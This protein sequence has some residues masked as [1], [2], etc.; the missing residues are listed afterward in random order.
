MK[1]E[2][3]KFQMIKLNKYAREYI[4]SKDI[5]INY[6]RISKQIKEFSGAEYVIFNIFEENGKDFKI[7]SLE[8]DKS[9]LNKVINVIGFKLIGKRFKYDK[10]RNEK[11]EK[12][13]VTKVKNL[14]E[15]IGDTLPPKSLK[16]L[17]KIFPIS[18]ILILR[19][20]KDDKNIGN[21]TLF[22]YEDIGNH[23]YDMLKLFASQVGLF[24]DKKKEEQKII[25]MNER[26]ENI[27]KGTNVGTWELDV[28]TGE[29]LI[30][31]RWAEMI[32]YKLEE[33]LP[34]TKE[35]REELIHPDDLGKL[36][37]Q[38]QRSLNKEIGSYDVEFRKRHKNGKWVW[39]N[40]RAKVTKWSEDGK[41]LVVSGALT[42]ITEKI[43]YENKIINQRDYMYKI[44]NS[45]TQYVIVIGLDYR[46]QFMNESAIENLGNIKGKICYKEL[47]RSK[48]CEG[49]RINELY[50]IEE[51]KSLKFVVNAFNKDLEISASKIE[52]KDGST[53]IVEVIDDITEKIKRQKKIEYLNFHDHLT[54]LHNRR[55]FEV[56]LERI[57]LEINLPL[58]IIMLD[59]NGLKLINDTF[60][61]NKGD[62]ILI[63]SSAAIKSV[64]KEGD[65]AIRSGGDEFLII[66]PKCNENQSFLIAERIKEKIK[67][68][69]ER[70]I[71]FS[72]ASGVHTKK[73]TNEKFSDVLKKV[74]GKMNTNKLFS[75]QSKRREV[76]LTMISTLHEKHPREEDHSIRVS[77]LS[78]K[79]GRAINLKGDKLRILKT[80]GLLHDI[81]K[82]GI[83]YSIIEKPGNLTEEE[84]QEVK[85]HPEIGYRILK[86]SIEYDNIAKIVLYHHEKLDGSGYP[87]GLKGD[88]IPLESRII[89]IVDSF[90]AMVASRPY[91]KSITIREAVDELKRCSG[92]QFDSVL[93]EAFIK[94]VVKENNNDFNQLYL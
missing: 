52:N 89:S 44:F 90:D 86:T 17:E 3:N 73:K 78:Y 39:I 84:Y 81:G 47:G 26:L 59:V 34:A 75:D 25:E 16:I 48:P 28:K 30:N 5:N 87:K 46:V 13:I 4:E 77:Q 38:F 12:N 27:I 65:I 62:E 80:A 83:D 49:C 68:K 31:E 51:N 54:G 58:S 19:I 33:I 8:G 94:D 36:K 29:S 74:E 15:L 1:M 61:H 85:K 22:F 70:G 64:L 60:G 32:G 72:L 23:D 10:E 41:A 63:K 76:I 57:N 42:D 7:V 14:K 20:T 24:I 37:R 92:T 69:S 55:F 67:D 43:K 66:L 82:I 35:K 71:P 18:H 2:K 11:F 79:L 50:T 88:F 91:K 21:F 6:Q 53:S 93:V 45:M 40:A 56:E 9:N